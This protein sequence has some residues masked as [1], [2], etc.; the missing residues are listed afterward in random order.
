MPRELDRI[1]Q[2][3][4]GRR[5]FLRYTGIAAGAGVLAACKKA[6]TTTPTAGGAPATHAPIGQEPGNL[7][8][9][10]WA[11]YGD[12][13]YGD[14][15]LWKNY[16]KEFPNDPPKFITFQEDPGFTKV[17]SG[18][19]YDIVH[20]CGYKFPDYV[21]LGV[22]QP[23]DTSKISNFPDLN[24]TLEKAG[25]ISGQQYFIVADWGFA[26]PM[27]RADKVTPKEDSWSLLWDTRYANR[28]AWED[29]LNMFIVAA[30]AN[31][32]TD[33]WNM[34]ADEIS[35]MKQFLITQKKAVSPQLWLDQTDIDQ[36]FKSEDV[37]VGYAWP[38]SWVVGEGNGLNLIYMQPK[39]GRTSW[40]CGFGLFK[41][42]QNY[43]HAHEYVNAWM[44][45]ESGAWLL[46]NYGYGQTNTKI[47]L[48]KIDPATVK[49]FSL[50]DPTVLD[51]PT[52]HVERPIGDRAAYSAA[53]DEVKAA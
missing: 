1:A 27:Y 18:T 49:A 50:D 11:G 28:I 23:W 35:Q 26:A 32:V 39:E 45:P 9:F 31:G 21:N 36:K 4:F 43:Y 29:S 24:P 12:G 34:T 19:T 20:P 38:A 15:V 6:T 8:V 17:A 14:D 5:D 47:D 52:T 3:Q 22:M 33:P 51:E 53:W 44:S 40:Y 10:D 7:Q 42:T 30:Y 16:K 46:N 25:V 13:A 2:R 37:Y 48:S 41:D